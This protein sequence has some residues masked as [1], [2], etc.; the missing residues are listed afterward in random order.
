MIRNTIADSVVNGPVVQIGSGNV[1]LA[2][3]RLDVA[4]DRAPHVD[5]PARMTVA[6]L[7]EVAFTLARSSVV[8][9]RR[10]KV[11]ALELV[12]EAIAIQ[13][14]PAAFRPDRH[15]L[16][17]AGSSVLLALAQVGAGPPPSARAS[18]AQRPNGRTG[19]SV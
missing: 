16:E 11:R 19:D 8:V 4:E 5:E 6:R 12:R 2:L 15:L 7:P 9:A 14:P 17:L 1:T 13:R 3:A 10:D 18:R